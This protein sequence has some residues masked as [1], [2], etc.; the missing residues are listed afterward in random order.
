M[1]IDERD[2]TQVDEELPNTHILVYKDKEYPVNIELFKYS[3][4]YFYEHE[5]EIN[6]SDR[7]EL[8]NYDPDGNLPELD[9][10]SIEIFINFIERKRILLTNENVGTLNYL[11]HKYEV[12]KLV[13]STE[14]YIKRHEDEVCL[15]L[16]LVHQNDGHISNGFYEDMIAEHFHK[17]VQ[18]EEMLNL[19][20]CTLY[21][22]LEKHRT[23]PKESEMK[24]EVN[25]FVIKAI[26]KYGKAASVLI[27]FIDIELFGIDAFF[28]FF[29]NHP[30]IDFGFVSKDLI[31]ILNE[32]RKK[33]EFFEKMSLEV[34]RLQNENNRLT[35]ENNEIK[36][37]YDVLFQ[38]LSQSQLNKIK[39]GDISKSISNSNN[40]NNDEKS[41]QEQWP[42]MNTDHLQSNKTN[43]REDELFEKEIK[44]RNESNQ[45]ETQPNKGLNTKKNAWSSISDGSETNNDRKNTQ[46]KTKTHYIIHKN[47][48][49]KEK[50]PK[51]MK[52]DDYF[53][54]D[55]TFISK[56]KK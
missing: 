38:S 1:Q 9:T 3:S 28:V 6:F 40:D 14:D 39:W 42:N 17:Y 36:S 37:K 55:E 18:K 21:R 44:S 53:Y 47:P 23:S 54:D 26:E 5:K 32:E 10:K 11:A 16:L 52:K 20:I 15:S 24:N 13:A 46:F 41:K 43:E 4:N 33:R 8:V 7:I 22:I 56:N 2:Y 31:K 51:I 27:Q 50:K 29:Q 30:D 49:N 35:K 45:I 25:K 19:N 34:A 48:Q 12:K